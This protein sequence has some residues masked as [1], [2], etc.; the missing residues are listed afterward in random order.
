MR[1]CSRLFYYETLIMREKKFMIT[2]VQMDNIRGLLGIRVSNP[3][4][5]MLWGMTNGVD[6]RNSGSVLQ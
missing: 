3:L 4:I 5:R 2:T 1:H 6:K